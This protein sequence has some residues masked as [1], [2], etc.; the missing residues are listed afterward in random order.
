MCIVR[1]NKNAHL[2]EGLH[3]NAVN[4]RGTKSAFNQ[5]TRIIHFKMCLTFSDAAIPSL[6][7]CQIF[8]ITIRYY[9]YARGIA[10]INV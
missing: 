1:V 8:M 9:I 6:L 2:Q 3:Q 7:L 10:T 5:I 4:F